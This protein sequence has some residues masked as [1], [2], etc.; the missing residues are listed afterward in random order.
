M[1]CIVH[2]FRLQWQPEMAAHHVAALAAVAAAAFRA[3]AHNYTLALL[4][5]ECT[6]PFVNL[7]WMLDKAVRRNPSQ[8]GGSVQGS[9]TCKLATWLR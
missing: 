1:T 4:A 9:A 5:T 8:H 7:R 6:T 3:H 2:V